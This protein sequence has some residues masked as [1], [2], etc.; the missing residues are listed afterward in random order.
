MKIVQEEIFGPVCAVIKFEDEEDVV[1]QAND[2]LYGLAAAVFTQDINR[3]LVTGNKLKA[4]TVWINCVNTLEANVPF[5]GCKQSG[6]TYHSF[7]RH[8]PP[9]LILTTSDLQL[10][11]SWEKKPC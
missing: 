4:G 6:S 3:A 1:R 7:S 2:T 10:V 8:P 11:A 9:D 5:G